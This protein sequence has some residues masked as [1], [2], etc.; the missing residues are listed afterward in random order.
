[1][2]F[3]LR[4]LVTA[5]A[6]FGVAY[7]SG[8]TLLRVDDFWPAAVSAAL[9]LS[10]VNAF[11]RPVLKVFAFPITV[12]TLGLF[13]LVVNAAMLSLVAAVVP[14]VR[15]TGFLATIV[16]SILIAIVSSVGTSLVDRD[17]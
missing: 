6:L 12:L 15:T 10:F 4:M 1:M 8:N 9:V 11:I 2:R 3:I 16:A 7:L 17:D 5:A 13:S 14:G